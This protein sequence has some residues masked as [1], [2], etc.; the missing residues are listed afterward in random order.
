MFIQGCLHG[1]IDPAKSSFHGSTLGR[2][3]DP[4]GFFSLRFV[5]HKCFLVQPELVTHGPFFH[6]NPCKVLYMSTWQ[7][8]PFPC[9]YCANLRSQPLQKFRCNDTWGV[10]SR[11]SNTMTPIRK[12]RHRT[13]WAW[14]S[15]QIWRGMT[16][17]GHPGTSVGVNVG[18]VLAYRNETPRQGNARKIEDLD[19]TAQ[20]WLKRTVVRQ[21]DQIR[22]RDLRERNRVLGAVSFDRLEATFHEGCCCSLPC[23]GMT[24]ASVD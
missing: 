14:A 23:G 2:P 4:V 15:R 9:R 13:S 3:R 16:R 17:V 12:S 24:L 21:T 11:E 19:H 5:A 22:M 7:H 1:D 8:F 20:Q 6:G 10:Y 18:L